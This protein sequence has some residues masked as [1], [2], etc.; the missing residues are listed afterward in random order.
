MPRRRPLMS[1]PMSNGR[2]TQCGR[3]HGRRRL[4]AGQGLTLPGKS[5]VWVLKDQKTR[6]AGAMPSVLRQASYGI[7]PKALKRGS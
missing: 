5:S 1:A 2:T 6:D 3:C 7:D 4:Q